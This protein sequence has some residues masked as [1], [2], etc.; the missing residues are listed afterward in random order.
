MLRSKAMEGRSRWRCEVFMLWWW[1]LDVV[2]HRWP[3]VLLWL[4]PL[5]S[6]F[7]TC[8][9]CSRECKGV[10]ASEKFV[11]W[12][13]V[14]AVVKIGGWKVAGDE[15]LLQWSRR[16][17]EVVKSCYSCCPYLFLLSTHTSYSWMQAE[18]APLSLLHGLLH[19]QRLKKNSEEGMGTMVISHD[20]YTMACWHGSPHQQNWQICCLTRTRVTNV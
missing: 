17:G 7:W 10:L 8:R 3:I 11:R 18:A 12:W 19:G 4:L 6:Y 2:V 13:I 14:G 15:K 20:E 9:L 16:V 1:C 5:F